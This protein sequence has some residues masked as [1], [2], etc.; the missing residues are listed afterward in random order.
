DLGAKEAVRRNRRRCE[1]ID[2]A[3]EIG[4]DG[5]SAPGWREA[6]GGFEAVTLAGAPFEAEGDPTGHLAGDQHEGL[7]AKDAAIDPGPADEGG[8][9]QCAITAAR[10]AGVG[11]LAIGPRPFEVVEPDQAAPVLI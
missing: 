2:R 8:S 4:H 9:I 3:G 7:D 6:I 5:N 1:P 10:Q 11:L